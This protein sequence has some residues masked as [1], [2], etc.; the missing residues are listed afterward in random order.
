MKFAG[1]AVTS[2]VEMIGEHVSFS[3]FNFFFSHSAIWI[4]I[5]SVFSYSSPFFS[6]IFFSPPGLL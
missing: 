2:V 5:K 3:K 6:R 4:T 1:N